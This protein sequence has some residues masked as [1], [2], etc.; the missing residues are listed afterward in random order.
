MLDEYQRDEAILHLQRGLV[1]ER[2]HRVDEAVEEYRRA[3]ARDPHLRE[4]HDALGLYYQRYGLYAKA[5]E[6]F[7]FVAKLEVGD[8][9]AHFNLGYV[10][11]EIGRHDEAMQV[12][13]HCL[14]LI[15]D[16]PATN[17]EVACL[18]YIRGSYIE[19]LQ[20]TQ[21][22]LERY[23][24]DWA[25]YKLRGCCM[26]RLG[27]YDEAQ[28]AFERARTWATRPTAQAEIGALLASVE[29]HRECGDTP[30]FK[31]QLYA[32]YGIVQLGSAQDDGI[33]L[34]E[35]AEYHFTYPDIATTLRR[36]VGLAQ[37]SAWGF[38]CV[39][40]L[41][42]L[43]APVAS[44]LSAMLGLPMCGTDALCCNARPLLVMAVGREQELL[45]I[46]R[47]RNG[48]CGASF[49]LGLNWLGRGSY[50]PDI[51]GVIAR[52]ACS[53][54]W[55]PELR[56]LRSLGAPAEQIDRC[57]ACALE[58]IMAASADLDADPT[59]GAQIDY[60]TDKH[61]NLRFI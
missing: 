32:S 14:S 44:A 53:V 37:A 58:Q 21:I 15:P 47:E 33:Q 6:E 5:A 25:L 23:A 40:G 9:L 43:A 8:F 50:H 3:I 16:D 12:F 38:T 19:S 27:N 55:E 4:A 39:I 51:I 24:E 52:G 17:Y 31:D 26:L 54:P 11:L 13:Q 2:A 57:L 49:C 36:M 45:D 41:D 18:H 61:P 7:R 60:Y 46:A 1:L 29:R 42:R 35:M 59:L 48:G 56:R 22:A 28:V 20:H 34:R 10:L 30:S